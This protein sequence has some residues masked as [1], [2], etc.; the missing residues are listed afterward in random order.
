KGDV[1]KTNI[2]GVQLMGM[3]VSGTTE[4][5]AIFVPLLE[6]LGLSSNTMSW[7]YN[8]VWEKDSAIIGDATVGLYFSV[9]V[10]ALVDFTVELSDVDQNGATSLIAKQSRQLSIQSLLPQKESFTLECDGFILR[11]NRTIKLTVTADGLDVL[12][13][14]RYDSESAASGIE[15]MKIQILDLNGNGIPDS[16]ESW[17][18][19][20]TV[21]NYHYTYQITVY[22]SGANNTGNGGGGDGDG[23][24]NDN[25]SGS[26][27]GGLP[28]GIEVYSGAGLFAGGT[29][30]SSIGLFRRYRI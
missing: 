6:G 28:K 29:L 14:M 16:D 5:Q 15:S 1:P 23:N 8:S 25:G 30:I 21:S 11:A 7:Y 26:A 2:K 17:Y 9:D 12:T 18:N 3:T 27:G 22:P 13:W 4:S 19:N 10:E 24:G 20:S